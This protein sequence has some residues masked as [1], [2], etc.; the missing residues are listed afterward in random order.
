MNEIEAKTLLA[1]FL[2]NAPE[3]PEHV[4]ADDQEEA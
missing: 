4:L 3:A 2:L 1:A